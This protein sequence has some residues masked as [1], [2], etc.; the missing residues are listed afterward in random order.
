MQPPCYVYQSNLECI[1]CQTSLSCILIF[2]PYHQLWSLV[3]LMCARKGGE[4]NSSLIPLFSCF[5]WFHFMFFVVVF[6]Q[7]LWQY[8]KILC[9]LELWTV[10]TFSVLLFY[11]IFPE[12][13]V[14]LHFLLNTLWCFI[15]L[16]NP[17]DL[18][19]KCLL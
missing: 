18:L 11:S 4:I 8:V 3:L 16:I 17:W 12:H 19:D 13:W 10:S 5:C 14:F 6:C 9:C 7:Y 2:S 15:C 1:L